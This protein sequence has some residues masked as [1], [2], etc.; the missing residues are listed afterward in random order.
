MMQF[1]AIR[2]LTK[3]FWCGS[4]GKREIHCVHKEKI[5]SLTAGDNGN[6]VSVKLA[7][8]IAYFHKLEIK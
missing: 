7:R 3:R 1:H 2:I 4:V 5:I 6:F 8:I